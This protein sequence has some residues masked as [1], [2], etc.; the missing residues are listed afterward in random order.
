MIDV[1]EYHQF[2]RGPTE[3]VSIW[4]TSQRVSVPAAH[5]ASL[6]RQVSSRRAESSSGPAEAGPLLWPEPGTCGTRLS[7][8]GLPLM[9]DRDPEGRGGARH[10]SRWPDPW[11]PEDDWG[12]TIAVVMFLII[13]GGLIVSAAGVHLKGEW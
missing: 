2:I 3:L 9:I 5:F 7:P 12:P 1:S 13:L 6:R 4:R 10:Y 8:R 11:R